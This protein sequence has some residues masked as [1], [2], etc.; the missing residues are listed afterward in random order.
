MWRT[1]AITTA[2]IAGYGRH[3]LDVASATPEH[4]LATIDVALPHLDLRVRV[5]EGTLADAVRT[6]FVPWGDKASK[7][8]RRAEITVLDP[9]VGDTPDPLGWGS[10]PY[11]PHEIS[12]S[13]SQ[14][15]LQG[16]LFHDLR[17][18]QFHD[19]ATGQGVQLMAGPDSFPPWEPGAPLRAFLHWEY[20][21]QG[22]RMTHAGTLGREGRGVLLAGAGGSG[23]SGT[24]LAG[25]LH[26][27]SSVGDDYVLVD[28]SENR[29]C[30]FPIFTTLKQDE[31]GARR[32]HLDRLLGSRELNWQGKVQFRTSDIEADIARDGLSI[33]AILLPKVGADA[34]SVHVASRSEAMLGLAPSAVYQMPGERESGFRFFSRLVSM[35]PAYRLELGP[36]PEEIAAVLWQFMD[37]LAS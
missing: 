26:G 8:S 2:T 37:E 19:L 6:A 18:W 9:T 20:A 31:R 7:P 21:A 23:K 34:T 4:L 3:L 30:A 13:L 17:F 22:R 25:L 36:D 12:R 28:L 27:L 15:G 24:V 5:P 16:S 1:E 29:V 33:G 35:L 32:L 11:V 10:A 14:V